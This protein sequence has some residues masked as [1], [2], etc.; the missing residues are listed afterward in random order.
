MICTSERVRTAISRSL[1]ATAGKN[2]VEFQRVRVQP[3]EAAQFP[4]L[5]QHRSGDVLVVDCQEGAFAILFVE[6][7]ANPHP[8]RLPEA[9]HEL[10]LG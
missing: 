3:Q 7:N 4:H 6:H 10:E 1:A 9:L 8:A 2:Q 5:L